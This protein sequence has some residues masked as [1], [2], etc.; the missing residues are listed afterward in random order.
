MFSSWKRAAKA[1]LIGAGFAVALLFGAG[2]DRARDGAGSISSQ[3]FG[4]IKAC[5]GDVWSLC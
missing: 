1:R 4:I 2:A 3:D 5:A